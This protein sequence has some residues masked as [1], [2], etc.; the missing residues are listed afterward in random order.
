MCVDQDES[1]ITQILNAQL[2]PISALC[3]TVTA[4]RLIIMFS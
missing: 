1:F 2:F 4:S 3:T